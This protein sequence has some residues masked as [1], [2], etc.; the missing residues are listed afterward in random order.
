MATTHTDLL[1]QL[2]RMVRERKEYYL[3]EVYKCEEHG[4]T[5]AA[6]RCLATSLAYENVGDMIDAVLALNKELLDQFD[7]FGN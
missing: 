7:Y 3:K 1:I 4:Q 2:S 5:L 6:E